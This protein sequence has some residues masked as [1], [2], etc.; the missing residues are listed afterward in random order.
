MTGSNDLDFLSDSTESTSTRFVTFIGH[1]L[2]RFDLAV[3]TTN[4]FYGK[5]LVTDLQNGRTAILG[6]DD[7]EEEGYLEHIFSLEEQEGE[8][9]RSFLYQVVGDPYFT[10]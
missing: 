8:E 4:R 1:S 5:K 9:M 2:K 3:T 10:D 7:L 6:T